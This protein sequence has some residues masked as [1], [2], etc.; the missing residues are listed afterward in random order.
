MNSLIDKN[1]VKMFRR[2]VS[3]IL[4]LIFSL[5]IV[6]PPDIARAQVLPML[7]LPGAMVTQSPGY[8]PALI[9]GITIDPQNPLAFDFIID[10]GMNRTA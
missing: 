6:I 3:L 1:G 2:I 5:G 9:K 4:I 8:V 7:P 10:T